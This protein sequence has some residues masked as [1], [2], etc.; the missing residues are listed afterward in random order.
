VNA[1]LKRYRLSDA[2]SLIYEFFW[3]E[4]C[5][6]YIE[7]SKVKLTGGD[8]AKKRRAAAMLVRVLEGCMRLL[9]PF[10]P[11]ITEEIWQRLP[12]R[13]ECK[14]VM[15]APYP[16]PEPGRAARGVKEKIG[17]LKEINYC[18]RNIRGEMNVPPEMKARVLVRTLDGKVGKLLDEFRGEILLLSRLESLEHGPGLRKPESSASAVGRGFEVYVPLKGLIDIEREKTRLKKE[19]AK[20]DREIEAAGNRLRNPDFTSRAPAAVVASQRARLQE[21]ESAFARIGGILRSLE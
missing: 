6:W 1:L 16:A 5:D 17:I 19:L 2:T 11:F 9:H 7:I 15:V 10:M 13:K 3:H 8:E 12:L 21:H 18:I 4:F 20:L 14:S